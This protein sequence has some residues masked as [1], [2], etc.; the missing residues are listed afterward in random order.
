MNLQIQNTPPHR[1]SYVD[2]TTHTTPATHLSLVGYHHADRAQAEQFISKQFRLAYNADIKYFYP[3]LLVLK[4]STGRIL[5]VAGLRPAKDTSLFCEHYLTH[6]A[7]KVI[8]VQRDSLIEVGNLVSAS[9]GYA[10][11]LVSICTAFLYG[12]GFSQVVF[13]LIP[14]LANTFQRMG[15]PLKS[16]ASAQLDKLPNDYDENWGQYYDQNP[17]VFTGRIKYGYHAL[18]TDIKQGI[19]SQS[20]WLCALELGQQTQNTLQ[21]LGYQ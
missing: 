14:V 18:L 15:L 21:M 2:P 10:R 3:H 4:N 16:I 7:E 12:A 11:K 13:T 6:K 20:Q 9:A 1:S 17:Q 19:E 5:A 8:G